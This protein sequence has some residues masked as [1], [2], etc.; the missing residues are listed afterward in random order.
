MTIGELDRRITLEYPKFAST[1]YGDV[2]ADGYLAWRT[3]WAKVEWVGGSETNETDKI[4]AIT[5]VNFY[6]RNLDLDEFISGS[7]GSLD[8]PTMSWRLEYMDGGLKKKYYIHN[9]EQIE[10]RDAFMKIITQEKD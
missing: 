8:N 4:T 10:G 5:K 2:I 9:V 7:G 6:I 1:A 3:V